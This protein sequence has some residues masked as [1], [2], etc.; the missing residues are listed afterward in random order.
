[1]TTWAEFQAACG[2]TDTSKGEYAFKMYYHPYLE[3]ECPDLKPFLPQPWV[4]HE[5]RA[6]ILHQ[7][8][9]YLYF[10]LKNKDDP[11]GPIKIVVRAEKLVGIYVDAGFD[12]MQELHEALQHTLYAAFR[13]V[14]R[15]FI[16]RALLAPEH[17]VE[18]YDKHFRELGWSS[19]PESHE[20]LAAV[21]RHLCESR[22]LIDDL[23]E[24]TS[25]SARD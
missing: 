3:S 25:A 15:Q 11:W 10:A 12:L 23:K 13:L 19:D 5:A 21:K 6:E 4:Q 8:N 17:E 18:L 1:M 7:L 24:T 22:S 14:R 2:K 16:K 9:S 20:D